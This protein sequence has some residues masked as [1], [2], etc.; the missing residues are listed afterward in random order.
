MARRCLRRRSTARRHLA[1]HRSGDRRIPCVSPGRRHR[2]HSR[3]TPS[4]C[5]SLQRCHAQ[6]ALRRYHQRP[7]QTEWIDAGLALDT[8][9]AYR[10]YVV[11]PTA[12]IPRMARSLPR[13]RSTTLPFVDGFEDGD[14]SWNF[15][16]LW[17]ITTGTNATG[18]ACL[19]DSPSASTPPISTA[20]I[21]THHG[22]RLTGTAWPVLR[23]K[24]RH[25]FHDVSSGDYGI[26]EV[27]PDGSGWT[28]VYAVSGARAEWAEQAIDLHA[29]AGRPTSA[30]ASISV[31]T[32][33]APATAAHRRRERGRAHAWC[34]AGVALYRALRGRTRQLAQRG[35]ARRR[36]PSR[37][38]AP[39]RA[40]LPL[41]RAEP[42][43]PPGSSSAV[44]LNLP[45]PPRRRSRSGRGAVGDDY[46]GLFCLLSKDGGLS[47]T[48]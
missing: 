1:A 11:S 18:N 10:V 21:T 13:A 25:A 20:A 28:R 48:I 26:L 5:A 36:T 41:D 4:P 16:G 32:A 45:V 24:D 7:E 14:L 15:S 42:L 37:A 19:T 9:Y 29:G 6:L 47:G 35:R 34:R 33:A 2:A 46:A 30:S 23:F 44:K 40:T 17:G 3:T 43:E 31:A 38:A 12:P 39:P 8:E 27:S 22:C